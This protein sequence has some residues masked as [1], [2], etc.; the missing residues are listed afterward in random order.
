MARIGDAFGHALMDWHAG[1]TEPEIFERED[2]VRDIG[3]GHE[4]YFESYVRWPD[5]EKEALGH[6]S[7]RVLDIGCGAGRVALHLQKCG[8]DVVGLDSS[9]LAIKTARARG[10][11]QVLH[12]RA[13][14]LGLR[15]GSFDTVV[16][17]GNNFG[18]FG[19]P[20][21][22]RTTLEKWAER[23]GPRTR[24]FAESSTPYFG[25]AP[26]L[27]RQYCRRNRE[28]GRMSGQVRLRI[29]Y[30]E[31]VTPW[32]DWFFVSRAEMRQLLSST[33]WRVAHI[34]GKDVSEPYVALIEKA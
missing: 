1:G 7:G 10:L 16:L 15:I 13:E 34:F 21:Q 9:R 11:R 30:R 19:S 5:S 22:L 26:V 32:F 33:G 6:A 8:F 25:G 28:A 20:E 23:T 4:L 14:Q 2:G 12:V 3:A 31:W 27:D 24:I 29:C 17:F 18:M